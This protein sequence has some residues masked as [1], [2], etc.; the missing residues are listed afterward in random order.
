MIPN[1]VFC[2]V[3]TPRSHRHDKC[4]K[5]ANK[6]VLAPI[7]APFTGE[8]G[9]LTNTWGTGSRSRCEIEVQLRR[10]RGRAEVRLRLH[11][12]RTSFAPRL[13][14]AHTLFAPCLRLIRKE[15][16]ADLNGTAGKH[17][18]LKFTSAPSLE[19][20]WQPRPNPSQT[21]FGAKR[22]GRCVQRR[23]CNDPAPPL[24]HNAQPGRW[25]PSL[26]QLEKTLGRLKPGKALDIWG[27]S[28]GKQPGRSEA[29]LTWKASSA[30]GLARQPSAPRSARHTQ[31]SLAH[32]YTHT[33][34][35]TPASGFEEAHRGYQA[36]TG[37][38]SL[39]ESD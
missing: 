23:P 17:C 12:L 20:A 29:P 8:K 14:L 28:S 21:R 38:V 36:Y 4:Q 33:H 34:T 7:D 2:N 6:T 10:N 16:W 35:H 9:W 18:D 22:Q 30:H 13:H 15:C 37:R 25:Q 32:T 39:A 3:W 31:F 11:L 26:P 19:A 24:L 5:S 27:W 1:A